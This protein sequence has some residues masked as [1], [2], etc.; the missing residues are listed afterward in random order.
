[1][2]DIRNIPNCSCENLPCTE[3]EGKTV[4]FR[5]REIKTEYEDIKDGSVLLNATPSPSKSPCRTSVSSP[6]IL[7][8][9]SVPNSQ[10]N[11]KKNYVEQ[12]K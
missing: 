1:M 7:L 10:I 11:L 12:T 3:R 2:K 4:S 5:K 6:K 8:E 9:R